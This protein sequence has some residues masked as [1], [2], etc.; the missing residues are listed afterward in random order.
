VKISKNDKK[1]KINSTTFKILVGSL[2]YLTCTH[3]DIPF[4]V[5]LVSRFMKMLTMTQFKALKQILRYI[6]GTV[7]FGFFYGYFSSFKLVSYS[8]SDWIGDMDA[9][10]RTVCFVFYIEDTTFT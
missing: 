4:G 10:K 7:V 6:K 9:R 1:E 5:R 8:D 3:S 2:R